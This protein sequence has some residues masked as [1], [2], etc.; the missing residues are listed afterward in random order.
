MEVVEKCVESWKFY[1]PSYKV[2]ILNKSNCRHYIDD[3][4]DSIKHGKDSM[5]RF[6]DY[7]RLCVLAKYGGFWIDASIICHHP[8][9]WLHGVQKK[10]D[11]EL[12][13]YYMDGF[14]LEEYKPYCPVIESWFF[15]C[16]PNSNY[17]KDW[18]NEF[19]STKDYNTID[20]YLTNID[21]Q[22]ISR[23]KIGGLSN[24]LAIHIAAQKIMQTNRDKYN[25]CLFS[26]C[27]GPLKPLCENGWDSPFFVLLPSLSFS[28]QNKFIKLA[29]SIIICFGII[30]FRNGSG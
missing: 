23:Q 13:G 24:Y 12:V 8:F 1:N 2:V 28:G 9:T 4:I 18:K 21:S 14:T 16:I 20:D 22:L 7:V 26:E 27:N 6:S 3:D 29:V 11:V 17:M 15:A 10:L 25:I 5:A 19:L 30:L